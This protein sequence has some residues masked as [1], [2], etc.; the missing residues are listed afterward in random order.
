M[1]KITRTAH[2]HASSLRTRDIT[3]IA[4]R[5][6]AVHCSALLPQEGAHRAAS[7]TTWRDAKAAAA[8]HRLRSSRTRHGARHLWPLRS[9]RLQPQA[10]AARR[11][12]RRASLS[13]ALMLQPQHAGE[14]ASRTAPLLSARRCAHA[15][16]ASAYARR[17]WLRRATLGA[18]YSRRISRLRARVKRK[19]AL[20]S[21]A[22]APFH[23]FCC[24]L[25]A[26]YRIAQK[27]A[28]RARNA[29]PHHIAASFLRKNSRA[30]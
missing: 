8:A 12:A 29:Q 5:A 18:P 23:I 28:H 21:A 4:R 24:A 27:C 11:A 22:A 3:L 9:P 10:A 13:G 6:L 19:L 7:I 26:H 2:W 16:H 1:F 20:S 15:H 25:C 17:T 14:A 30:F